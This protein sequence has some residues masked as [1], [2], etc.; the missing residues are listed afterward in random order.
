MGLVGRPAGHRTRP[1]Q[2]DP[3]RMSGVMYD[4]KFLSTPSGEIHQL[5]IT[6]LERMRGLARSREPIE[7]SSLDGFFPELRGCV[8]E[9]NSGVGS[10][11]D[12]VEPF[13]FGAM[14]VWDG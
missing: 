8:V 3:F 1:I 2:H 6:R 5:G 12:Y 7:L 10:C 13:V 9:D 4:L 11:F 14:P